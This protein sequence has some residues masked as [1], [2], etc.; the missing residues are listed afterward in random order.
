MYLF[1]ERDWGGHDGGVRPGRAIVHTDCVGNNPH[2]L[3]PRDALLLQ[4]NEWCNAAGLKGSRAQGH[5]FC[6][7]AMLTGFTGPAQWLASAG[8]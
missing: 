2:K 1:G 8:L 3:T 4:Q 5:H 6:Q 7:L